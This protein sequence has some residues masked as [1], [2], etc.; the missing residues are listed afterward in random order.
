MPLGHLIMLGLRLEEH[1]NL[2]N[3]GPLRHWSFS[4]FVYPSCAVLNYITTSYVHSL[5]LFSV[6]GLSLP[7]F[8]EKY[9][10][11]TKNTDTFKS[12]QNAE[13]VKKLKVPYKFFNLNADKCYHWLLPTANTKPWLVFG[14]NKCQFFLSF[15]LLVTIFDCRMSNSK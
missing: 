2:V 1:N 4:S 6:S 11:K 5:E 15:G 3:L 7:L 10:L 9:M 14:W 13:R 8:K 12:I